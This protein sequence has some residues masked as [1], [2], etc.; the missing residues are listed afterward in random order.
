M[1]L[2]LAVAR[3]LTVPL[4]HATFAAVAGHCHHDKADNAPLPTP[5][6]RCLRAKY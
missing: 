4:P 1:M 2:L 3:L 6:T 5:N